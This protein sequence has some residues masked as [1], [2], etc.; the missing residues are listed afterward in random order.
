VRPLF[1]ERPLPV[2]DHVTR[3]QGNVTCDMS[4][5]WELVLKL[6]NQ[7][8]PSFSTEAAAGT[9]GGPCKSRKAPPSRCLLQ[10]SV[11]ASGD[12]QEGQR[13]RTQG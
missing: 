3:L 1:V 11:P 2:P 12:V 8:S 9:G 13:D 6:L 5:L 4:Y 7:A 10:G